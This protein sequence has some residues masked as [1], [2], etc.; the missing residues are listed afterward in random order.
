[1]NAKA[2]HRRRY[3]A[4]HAKP[5]PGV[6]RMFERERARAYVLTLGTCGRIQ[7]AEYAASVVGKRHG[8]WRMYA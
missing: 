6:L 2:R 8:F 5:C 4:A 3:R 7:A 1:M